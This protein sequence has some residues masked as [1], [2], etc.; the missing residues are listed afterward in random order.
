MHRTVKYFATI[1][2]QCFALAVAA[3][4]TELRA[5]LL[6]KICKILQ[7]LCLF[8]NSAHDG[9]FCTSWPVVCKILRAQN[10]DIPRLIYVNLAPQLKSGGFY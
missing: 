3:V 8:V 2:L 7:F 10:S 4:S 6:N 9:Q 5:I 1:T